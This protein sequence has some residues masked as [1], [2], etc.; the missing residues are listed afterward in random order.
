V[1]GYLYLYYNEHDGPKASDARFLTVARTRLDDLTGAVACE[2]VPVFKKFS[3]GNWAE[4][5]MTGI[6]SA[7]IPSSRFRND[8]TNAYDF[9]SDATYCKPLGRYLITVQTHG[10]NTLLLYS[11]T[12]GVDWQFTAE[13]DRAPN[14][15][16]PYS[17]FISFSKDDAVDGHEVGSEFYIYYPR[18]L[19]KDY[20]SDTLCRISFSVK[21]SES[22]CKSK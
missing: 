8:A 10:D 19:R 6:G 17:S 15:M 4:D 21:P 16:L 3:H 2:N 1:D 5:G 11:S 9:H 13:L 20:N 7:I 18:K 22:D 14:C 12:N